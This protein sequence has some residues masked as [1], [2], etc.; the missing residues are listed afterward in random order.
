MVFCCRGLGGFLLFRLLKRMVGELVVGSLFAR[1]R[2]PTDRCMQF[3]DL[4]VASGDHHV[5][6]AGCYPL[7]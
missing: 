3:A 1:V 4:A 6:G 2:Y 7:Q 5:H